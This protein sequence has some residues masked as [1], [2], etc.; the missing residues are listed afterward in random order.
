MIFSSG[1]IMF[2]LFGVVICFG[3]LMAGDKS[4]GCLIPI[5][6]VVL[7]MGFMGFILSAITML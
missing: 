3:K 1:F 6:I 4:M 5:L 7:L 2:V